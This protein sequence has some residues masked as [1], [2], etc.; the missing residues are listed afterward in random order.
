[1]ASNFHE[2]YDR[3][4]L[5]LPSERSTGLVFTAV[6]LVIAILWRSSPIVFIGALG[7]AVIF[8]TLALVTPSVLRPLNIAWMRFAVL[9][10]KVM[11]PIIMFV[12]YAVV[13]VPAGLV[14][15]L[16]YDPLRRRRDGAAKT[17]WVESKSTKGSSMRNQF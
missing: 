2:R 1:M 12:L 5:P 9:L 16:R 13:I 10:G 15:Q 7:A 11:N 17:Y 4:E 6:A 14:M 3:D 8:G